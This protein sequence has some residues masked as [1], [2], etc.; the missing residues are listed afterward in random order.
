MSQRS[1]Q[2]YDT[3]LCDISEVPPPPPPPPPAI[4]EALEVWYDIGKCSGKKAHDT[5]VGRLKYGFFYFSVVEQSD[6]AVDDVIGRPGILGQ[7]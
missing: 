3:I 7:E 6:A 5:A 2:R 1:I 4:M